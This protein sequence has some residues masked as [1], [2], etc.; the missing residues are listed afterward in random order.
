MILPELFCEFPRPARVSDRDRRRHPGDESGPAFLAGT[1]S[2][3][4]PLI[5]M[6]AI[7]SAAGKDLAARKLAV[8]A[9]DG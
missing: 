1:P 9:M 4:L 2:R 6:T 3:W 8:T 7:R 5:V